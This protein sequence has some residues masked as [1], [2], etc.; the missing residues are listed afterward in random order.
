MW[1][2]TINAKITSGAYH[3]SFSITRFRPE[4]HDAEQRRP[5]QTT[6]RGHRVCERKVIDQKHVKCRDKRSPERN[7]S[8]RYKYPVFVF[9]AGDFAP[10]RKELRLTVHLIIQHSNIAQE[11]QVGR[12][13][14]YADPDALQLRVDDAVA[15]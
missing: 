7:Q 5:R 2:G 8:C 6:E 13:N 14:G 4:I 15:V 9:M 12:E 11:W 10:S 3:R 1:I